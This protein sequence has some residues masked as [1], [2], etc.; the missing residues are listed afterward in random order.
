M[1]FQATTLPVGWSVQPDDDWDTTWYDKA[2]SSGDLRA[3]RYPENGGRIVARHGTQHELV[4]FEPNPVPLIRGK[5]M[6]P[7][8]CGREIDVVD[9]KS[10]Q[11]FETFVCWRSECSTIAGFPARDRLAR[12]PAGRARIANGPSW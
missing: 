4:G 5:F 10:V 3:A 8:W 9:P 2:W 6:A 1:S 12:V 11:A 7:C